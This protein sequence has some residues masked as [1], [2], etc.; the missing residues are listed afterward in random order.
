MFYSFGIIGGADGPTSILV[1]GNTVAM[2]PGLIALCIVC[3]L[4]AYFLGNISPA[5]LIARAHGIDIKKEGSGN[6]G[7]TNVLRV[8]GKKAA[9]MTLVIDI[10]KGVAAVLIGRFAGN[11]FAPGLAPD[12]ASNLGELLAMACAFFVVLGHIWPLIFKFKGGKGVATA[13]G[14]LVALSPLLGIDALVIVGIVVILTR[15]MSAGSVCG[16]ISVPVLSYFMVPAFFPLA[17]LLALIILFKHRSNIVR[18]V[19]GQE[20]KLNF[21]SKK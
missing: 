16:A 17:C 15:R 10:F 8:L 9:I 18:L 13:F 1:N 4:I 11:Y 2:T 3:I 5:T 19:K 20:P 6:A 14:A 21:G 7:T 12:F